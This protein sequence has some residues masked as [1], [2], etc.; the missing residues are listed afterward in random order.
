M[1]YY[2]DIKERREKKKAEYSK[3]QRFSYYDRYQTTNFETNLKRRFMY[4][5]LLS[6]V[7]FI[8]VI[9]LFESDNPYAQKSQQFIKEAL[10]R[11]YNFKGF[12]NLY[13][14][15]FTGNS[16]ILPS[17]E[18]VEKEK[19]VK[20]PAPINELPIEIKELETGIYIETNQGQQVRAMDKG[21]VTYIGETESLGKVI[22]I[23]HQNEIESTY[24]LLDEINVEKDGWVEQGGLI[25]TT[26]ERLYISLRSKG[27]Y[28]NPLEVIVFE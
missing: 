24:G 14:A 9:F 6:F 16:A 28:L 2:D 17:F 23:M 5:L 13:Q 18:I 25:G 7:L 4:K 26:D 3:N 22:K 11:D 1:K 21:I 27:E 15:K 10:T 20:L 12:Y 19:I 8:F